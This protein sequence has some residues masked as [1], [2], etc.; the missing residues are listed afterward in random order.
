MHAVERVCEMNEPYRD[1]MGDRLTFDRSM[2]GLQ[3]V[4]LPALLHR[5]RRQAGYTSHELGCDSEAWH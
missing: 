5:W 2:P 4:R 3:G 1:T